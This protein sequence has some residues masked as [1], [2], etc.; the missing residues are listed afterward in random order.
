MLHNKDSWNYQPS[1]KLDKSI[2]IL[3]YVFKSILSIFIKKL[4]YINYDIIFG[5][6]IPRFQ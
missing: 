2:L 5:Y 4:T 3:F 1:Y 6:D